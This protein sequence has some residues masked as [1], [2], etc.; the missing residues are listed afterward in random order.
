MK[1]KFDAVLHFARTNPQ[2]FERELQMLIG[3]REDLHF[4]YN[5]LLHLPRES[6][7][8]YLVYLKE[9]EDTSLNFQLTLVET[10]L[11]RVTGYV[12]DHEFKRHCIM[13]KQLHDIDAYPLAQNIT[14]HEEALYKIVD[15]ALGCLTFEELDDFIGLKGG[16]ALQGSSLGPILHASVTN[17][18]SRVFDHFYD[19]FQALDESKRVRD[20]KLQ[21]WRE[22]NINSRSAYKLAKLDLSINEVTFLRDPQVFADWSLLGYLSA[23][24]NTSSNASTSVLS[25]RKLMDDLSSSFRGCDLADVVITGERALACLNTCLPK[26][27]VDLVLQYLI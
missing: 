12:D 18:D 1:E 20:L 11:R 5:T 21:T 9:M 2:Q 17:P 8:K 3:N 22:T 10:A 25:S 27:L 6:V 23:C 26:V 13:I 7:S 19:R 14:N 4:A 15:R 24:T 16:R